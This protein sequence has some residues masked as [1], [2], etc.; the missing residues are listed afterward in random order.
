MFYRS[1]RALLAA[2]AILALPVAT[3]RADFAASKAWFE[4]YLPTERDILH[5]DLVITGA[6]DGLITGTFTTGLYEALRRV[7]ALAGE[8]PTGVLSFE[9]R[10]VLYAQ[11]EAMFASYGFSSYPDE[12]SGID[13]LLPLSILPRITG[14]REQTLFESANQDFSLSPISLPLEGS[15]ATTFTGPYDALVAT[16]GTTMV[17]HYASDTFLLAT[18]NSGSRSLYLSYYR[19]GPRLIGFQATWDAYDQ[20]FYPRLAAIIASSYRPLNGEG[21]IRPDR[22]KANAAMEHAREVMMFWPE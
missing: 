16:P 9:T 13:F 19:H 21:K 18:G 4:D 3:A 6:Y 11:S 22:I 5:G 17:L 14:T 20:I 10:M 15:N 8:E 7:Q 12:P 1:S 2:L